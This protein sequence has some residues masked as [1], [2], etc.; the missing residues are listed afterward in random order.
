MKNLSKIA[1]GIIALNCTS[2]QATE[3]NTSPLEFS[4]NV[5]IT[6]DYVFRGYTQTDENIA[7]Q[8]GFDVAHKSGFYAGTW[9][10][11]VKFLDG[12]EANIEI[13]LYLGFANELSNGLSYDLGWIYYA[14]PGADSNL[15]YDSQELKLALGYAIDGL[16]LGAEY[17]YS[18]DFFGAGKAHYFTTNVG[19]TFAN[20]ISLSA[21]VGR[22]NFDDND[23]DYTDYGVSA[24]YAL[25]GFDLSLNYSDTNVDTP[26]ADSR[27]SFTV[28]KSF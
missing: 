4:A 12:D 8:G 3:Q 21:H 22:Q 5:A 13:D 11:N 6:S 27:I 16:A 19:Y 25:S 7:L 1:F 17:Y 18:P 14:Y 20:D 28:G 24:S 9:G 10:S 26:A 15:N 2:V 23:S